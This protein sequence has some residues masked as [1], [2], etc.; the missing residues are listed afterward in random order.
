[1]I[2]TLSYYP[3]QC[4]RNAQAPMAA[5]LDSLKKFGIR[6][7][8][9]SLNCD[10]AIIW[11][12]LWNGRMRHNQVV[13]EHYRS[14]GLP[15]II[16]DV[17]ALQ[18]G[19]T[20]KVAVNHVTA[21]GYYG[22]RNNLDL[23]RP[24]KLGIKLKTN[25]PKRSNI[26]IAAQHKKSHQL[27]QLDN[28]ELWINQTVKKIKEYSDRPI[29]I[30]PHPRSDLDWSKIDPTLIK[31]IPKPLINTYDDFDLIYDCYAVVNYNSS[32][33]IQ[34]SIVGIPALVD[35]S[36]LAKPVSIDIDQIEHPYTV[37]REKWLIEISHTEYLISELETGLWLK[38]IITFLEKV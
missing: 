9:N 38:R 2:K 1:V 31:E 22:H 26:L 11:S 28:Y 20:W 6:I 4:A 3:I 32:P 10:A 18:R 14:Q 25:K 30:R 23:D 21:D 29:H 8:E 33:G 37:D 19:V 7:V 17:G 34:S 35:V 15:V 16:V 12:V 36:S 5:I 13:Y 27:A 24:K